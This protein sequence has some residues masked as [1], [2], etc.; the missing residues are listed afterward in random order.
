MLT[1][2][3]RFYRNN[4]YDPSWGTARST[5]QLRLR[6]CRSAVGIIRHPKRVTHS[7]RQRC[8]PIA[9]PT[10][11]ERRWR[12]SALSAVPAAAI[13]FN[14]RLYSRSRTQL[15]EVGRLRCRKTRSRRSAAPMAV[16]WTLGASA[17]NW[18]A[19]QRRRPAHRHMRREPPDFRKEAHQR[20]RSCAST[21]IGNRMR[22]PPRYRTADRCVP[23][24]T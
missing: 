21:P 8:L 23:C 18:F 3:N 17:S 22:C 7:Y 13:K 10:G 6:P 1:S 20:P 12:R 15:H 2:A 19:L 14:I 11:W 24:R 9:Q 4:P 16:G 5:G